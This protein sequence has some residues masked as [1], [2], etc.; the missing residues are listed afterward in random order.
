V[1]QIAIPVFLAILGSFLIQ[2][3]GNWFWRWLLADF[4]P[5][6]IAGSYYWQ[7]SPPPHDTLSVVFGLT[8][9]NEGDA[10]GSIQNIKFRVCFPKGDWVLYGQYFIDPKRY[11]EMFMKRQYDDSLWGEPFRPVFLP[12]KS[13]IE[14]S[15]VFLR[16]TDFDL[17]NL[18]AGG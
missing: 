1:K 3:L 16:G 5:K 8:L 13:Q 18:E 4:E 15:V 2:P 12:P 7:R 11:Y 17:T 9:A 10:S 14:K 6:V